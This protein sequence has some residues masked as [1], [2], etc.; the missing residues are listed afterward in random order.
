MTFP[1]R[2]PEAVLQGAHRRGRVACRVRD[3]QVPENRRIAVNG[4]EGVLT[5]TSWS[6]VELNAIRWPA[7]LATLLIS[8]PPTTHHVPAGTVRL[9]TAVL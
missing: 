6:N 9:P 7:T 8:L 3:V 4:L 5:T 2:A 1:G